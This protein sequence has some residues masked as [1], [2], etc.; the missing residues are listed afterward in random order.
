MY[1]KTDFNLINDMVI[2]GKNFENLSDFHIKRYPK[3][4][5]MHDLTYIRTK[6]HPDKPDFPTD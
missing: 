4:K 6:S 5:I 2:D 1:I 3:E